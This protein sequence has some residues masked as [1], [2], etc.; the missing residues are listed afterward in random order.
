MWK[1]DFFKI[2]NGCLTKFILSMQVKIFWILVGIVSHINLL[3]EALS[4]VFEGGCYTALIPLRNPRF[5]EASADEK[6]KRE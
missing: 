1:T 6:E 2:V 5:L 4:K 3:T